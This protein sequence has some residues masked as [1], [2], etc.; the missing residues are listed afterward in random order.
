VHPALRFFV[1]RKTATVGLWVDGFQLHMQL[2]QFKEAKHVL[3]EFVSL[4]FCCCII[5]CG[6][7]H[8]KASKCAAQG[9]GLVL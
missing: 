8:S 4:W 6:V 3:A 1:A 5:A 9:V 2:K 7:F